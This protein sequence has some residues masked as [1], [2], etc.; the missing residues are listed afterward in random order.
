[1]HHGENGLLFAHDDFASMAEA[2][3]ELA[4]NRELARELG[5]R[6]REYV[7][8]KH[9]WDGNAAA[10]IEIARALIAKKQGRTGG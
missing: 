3:V 10:V 6:G 2:V 1:V 7:L 5:R 9:T 4:G 8:R